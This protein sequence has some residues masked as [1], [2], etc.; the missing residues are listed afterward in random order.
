MVGADDEVDRRD[1][2]A[3]CVEVEDVE[4]APARALRRCAAPRESRDVVSTGLGVYPRPD[5]PARLDD[6]DFHV[7]LPFPATRAVDLRPRQSCRQ[8]DRATFIGPG[9]DHFGP[10]TMS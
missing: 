10:A 2:G 3:Q 7:T 8:S 6:S 9:R 4:I 5:V 1:D